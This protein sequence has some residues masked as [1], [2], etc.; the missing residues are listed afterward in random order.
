MV[1]FI[2]SE[3]KCGIENCFCIPANALCYLLLHFDTIKE[4]GHN[5]HYK[6]RDLTGNAKC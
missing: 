2:D 3:E 1:C 5:H 4:G 6:S